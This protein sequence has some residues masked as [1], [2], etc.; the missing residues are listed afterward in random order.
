[1]QNK[2]GLKIG[3]FGSAACDESEAL[4]DVAFEMG[5]YI[6]EHGHIV[7]TGACEGLP[8]RAVSGAKQSG[9]RAI[10]FTA[11]CDGASHE[12]LMKTSVDQFDELVYIPTDYHYRDDIRVCRK[13]RN[14]V[15]V[16]HCDAALF[17]SGRWGTLNEF[18]IAFDLEKTIGVYT[19]E[20]KFS[21]QAKSLISFFNKP[22][23][24]TII[25]SDCP[26]DLVGRVIDSVI[27]VNH[28]GF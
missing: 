19:K 3:V 2:D 26:T 24:S 25:Y 22:S 4:C 7:V 15:S 6:A 11:A 5:R 16:S 14:I 18:S 21:T 10:G 12:T 27:E 28:V 8:H 17:I 13:Y 9:G 23:D 1:M 20:G